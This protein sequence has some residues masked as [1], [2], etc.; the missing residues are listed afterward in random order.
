MKLRTLL[1]HP[2][3]VASII[4]AT[5]SCTDYKCNDFSEYRRMP[6]E[7][8]RYADS[9]KFEP[10]H[11]DSL[12]RGRLVVGITHDDSYRFTELCM[13]VTHMSDDTL[14]RDT[15]RVPVVDR[16]GTWTGRGIG[17]SCQLTD[18]LAAGVHPSGSLVAVRHIMRTDTLVGVNKVGLFF[19]PEK[20]DGK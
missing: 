8:W 19:V 16:L 2:W 15:V 1:I 4:V 3:L 17:S 20:Q 9:I 7:G 12:C 13:E 11:A 14:H 10:V 6:P 5:S 18:T